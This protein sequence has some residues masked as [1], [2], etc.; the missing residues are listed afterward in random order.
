MYVMFRYVRNER[1]G[2]AVAL[3][4]GVLARMLVEATPKIAKKERNCKRRFYVGMRR[5]LPG[6]AFQASLY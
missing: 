1:H 6:F 5:S 3:F 4:Y 2:K